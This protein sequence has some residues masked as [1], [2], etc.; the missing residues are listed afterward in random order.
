MIPGEEP[1]AFRVDTQEGEQ[2]SEFKCWTIERNPANAEEFRP[3]EQLEL[4]AVY[5]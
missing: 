5:S 1:T 4:I 3:V 2:L